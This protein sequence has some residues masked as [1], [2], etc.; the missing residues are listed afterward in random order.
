MLKL[1]DFWNDESGAILSA[2]LVTVGTVAV[3]G[4]TV[5]LNTV[6]TSVNAELTDLAQAFRSLNQS[7]SVRGFSSCRASTAGSSFVQESVVVSVQSLCA[8]AVPAVPPAGTP[9][10][11]APEDLPPEFSPRIETAPPA[12]SALTP[13]IV[14]PAEEKL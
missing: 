2:E 5:G 11:L 6:A 12:P 1:R 8:C 13:S 4:T 3:I 7:Y 10:T 9:V 14:T